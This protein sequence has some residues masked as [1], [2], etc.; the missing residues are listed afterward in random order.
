M[1][2]FKH[3]SRNII[4]DYQLYY[5]GWHNNAV[6]C[7]ILVKVILKRNFYSLKTNFQQN[8]IGSHIQNHKI[9]TKNLWEKRF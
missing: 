1:M 7:M 2:L 6:Q 9:S 4:V 8:G 3:I 5:V